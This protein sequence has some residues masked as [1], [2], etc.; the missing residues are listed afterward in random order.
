M[1]IDKCHKN[2]KQNGKKKKELI[3]LKGIKIINTN[4]K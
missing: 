2:N 3:D 4:T 1:K